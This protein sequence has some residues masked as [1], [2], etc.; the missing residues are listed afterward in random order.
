MANIS[1]GK[2]LEKQ[3]DRDIDYTKN[4]NKKL[5]YE[6][7]LRK[8]YTKKYEGD[9]IKVEEKLA[10]IRWGLKKKELAEEKK[11]NLKTIS[12]YNRQLQLATD[13]IGKKLWYNLKATAAEATSAALKAGEQGINAY[14]DTYQK[15]MSGIST[16]LQ[17]FGRS[18]SDMTK[19]ISSAI[20]MSPYASQTKVMENL[21]S[22][23]EKG[24]AYNVEQRAFL[25][26][27]SDRIATTF[28]N[29]DSSLLRI[30]RIQQA[31]STAAR[32]GVESALTKFLNTSFSDTSYLNDVSSSISSILLGAESQLGYKG[33]TEFE[34]A[35]QKWLGS[36]YSVGV[37]S[38]TIQ[39]LAQGIGY[40]G[41]GDITA[42]SGNTG[43]QN[44]LLMGAQ[45]SGLDYGSMITGGISASQVSGLLKG[46]V[47]YIQSIASGTNLV[48]K[49]QYAN[50]FGLTLEDM[51]SLLNLT[52][53]DL[54]S[55]SQNMLTYSNAIN[56]TEQMLSS[57]GERTSLKD[58]IQNVME[59]TFAMMGE[60]IANSSALYGTWMFTN[61]LSK[62]GFSKAFDVS[63]LGTSANLLELTRLGIVG[64]TGLLSLAEGISGLLSSNGKLGLG[65]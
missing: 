40:L 59:N 5:D 60:K 64:G 53:Q 63:I 12:E 11:I 48:V 8:K 45:R 42:L 50:L 57:I 24:I 54:V 38:N 46:V 49:S 41:T 33:G 44:L 13:N 3:T 14:I 61:L 2:S 26:S 4:T 29:F 19:T 35:V 9:L 23:V 36:L 55:I 58:K 28:K 18:Y 27:V 47:E 17:G 16:R 21:S 1:L 32:L 6:Y 15:Y 25:A 43:L 56:Q 31:D 20:G 7:Q 62:S 65:K 39:S 37:S 22:L 52:S 30:I 10:E 51:T 34:Y